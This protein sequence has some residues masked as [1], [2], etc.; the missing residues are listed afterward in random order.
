MDSNLS[1]SSCARFAFIGLIYVYSAKFIDT[2]WHGIFANPAISFIIVS[3]N[4]IAGISQ[5]LF[6]YKLQSLSPNNGVAARIAGW[7]GVLGSLVNIIPKL[8]AFSVLLQFYFSLK[9]IKS[10][11]V[12]AVLSPWAGSVMLFCCCIINFLISLKLWINKTRFF[13]FGAVGYMTLAATFSILVFNFFSGAQVNWHVGESGTSL[14]YFIISASF[15]FLCIAYFYIGFFS[16]DGDI[17][18]NESL[19]E[20]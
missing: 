14:T 5:F 16:D 6:F 20:P 2:V 9:T 13:L 3:L 7:T 11:Q 17:R 18:S 4:I 15:S 1:L 19:N 10:S 8:L 12:I